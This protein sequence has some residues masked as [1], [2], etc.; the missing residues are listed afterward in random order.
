[1]TPN[2]LRAFSG[3]KSRPAAVAQQTGWLTWILFGMFD[4][5]VAGPPE[6]VQATVFWPQ[7]RSASYPWNVRPP[8]CVLWRKMLL[9]H[10]PRAADAL[11]GQEHG[12]SPFPLID[13][14]DQLHEFVCP[15]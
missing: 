3:P 9:P 2:L 13:R 8:G 10:V 1:M 4:E 7:V 14:I 15:C 11:R 12:T 5:G 6:L